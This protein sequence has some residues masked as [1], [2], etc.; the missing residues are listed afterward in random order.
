MH[1][2]LLRPGTAL[3]VCV[4]SQENLTFG[5]SQGRTECDG[6][7]M[8]ILF[9]NFLPFFFS[10]FPCHHLLSSQERNFWTI[11]L[12]YTH[13][14]FHFLTVSCVIFIF[15]HGNTWKIF[16]P[17]G[18]TEYMLFSFHPVLK[19]KGLLS[20]ESKL[21]LCFCLDNISREIS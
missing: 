12:S 1:V 17:S 11:S 15:C 6:A 5:V 2:F 9:S 13:T 16:V 4:H 7:V 18:H 20:P 19:L 21:H 3:K 8:N 14:Y 10:S